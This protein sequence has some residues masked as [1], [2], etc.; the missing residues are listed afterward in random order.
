VSFTIILVIG[1]PF[2]Y[3]FD[4]SAAYSKNFGKSS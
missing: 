2:S 3:A 1:S 4:S